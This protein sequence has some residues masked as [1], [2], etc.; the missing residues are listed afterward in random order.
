M[1]ALLE[2]IAAQKAELDRLRPLAP[3][4][5]SNLE[6]SADLELTFTSNAI[7]GNTLSAAETAL[8]IEQGH[9]RRRRSRSRSTWR[10]LTT[11]TPSVTCAPSRAKRRR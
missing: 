2:R 8:V 11:T 6:H 7:E 5:L 10:Q 3:G 4:G 1:D 9:H